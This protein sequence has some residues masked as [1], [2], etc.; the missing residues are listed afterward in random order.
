MANKRKYPE[1]KGYWVYSIKIPSVNKYYI[2]VSRRKECWQRWCK[3]NYKGTVIEPYFSE[4]NNMEKTVLVDNLSREDSYIYEGNIIR[5]LSMNNLCLNEQHSGLITNDKNTYAREY[6]KQY[7]L[8]N[9]EKYREYDRQYQKQRRLKKKLEKQ[10]HT[11][12]L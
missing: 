2:G 7:R 1:V 3:S 8:K 9:K 6:M 10:Q 4:W 11:S 12:L 5:A